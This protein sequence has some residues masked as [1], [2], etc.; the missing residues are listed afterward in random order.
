[1]EKGIV[2]QDGYLQRLPLSVFSSVCIPSF[3]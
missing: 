1:M 2:R 3:I